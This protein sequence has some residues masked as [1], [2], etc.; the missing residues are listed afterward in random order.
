MDTKLAQDTI[1]ALQI[2]IKA[3]QKQAEHYRNESIY[4]HNQV[5]KDRMKHEEYRAKQEEVLAF[6][7]QRHAIEVRKLK[8]RIWEGAIFYAALIVIL[9][10]LFR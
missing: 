1:A 2:D 6:K 4:W 8:N 7:E 3:A 5:S 10:I 9:Y